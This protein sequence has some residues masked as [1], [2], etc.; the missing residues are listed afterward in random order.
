MER[1]PHVFASTF[2]PTGLIAM[3]VCIGVCYTAYYFEFLEDLEHAIILS[4]GLISAGITCVLVIMHWDGISQ[5]WYEG[6]S[7]TYERFARA[8]LV[9][10]AAV[11]V[12]NS[13]IIEEGAGLS[14][15]S[16]SVLALMAWNIGNFKS[17]LLWIGCGAV[18][19]GSRL[20][21]G[22]REEQ[23]DCWTA[24]AG[25]PTGQA[26]RPALVLALGSVAGVVAISRRH[27]G[28]RGYGV[29]VAG[30]FV[31]SHWAVGW[32]SLG[33]PARARLLARS[34]WLVI[35]TMFALV[36]RRE[37][38][39]ASLPLMVCGLLIY[40]ANT[41]VLGAAYAPSAALA[42][43]VGFLALNLV[44]QLKNEGSSKF[45]EYFFLISYSLII[46]CICFLLIIKFRF[47]P[48]I[49]NSLQL[50]R[51]LYVGTISVLPVLRYGS[52]RHAG[53]RALGARIPRRRSQLPGHWTPYYRLADLA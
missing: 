18:L 21:R 36:W 48:S 37:G 30:L 7:Q 35:A 43:V 11:L 17:L 52:P 38:R 19:A 16:M 46:I 13:Y 45:C 6:R 15:L 39:G 40:V 31:C 22:C 8:A 9:A 5:R 25:V 51:G 53:P 2:V 24:G 42:I 34:A 3:G 41:L 32:G 44:S 33:S 50:K 20:Y 29:V 28:W 23:G 49:D 4:T 26:S 10:S 1:L 27:V 47:L 14:F 12:S